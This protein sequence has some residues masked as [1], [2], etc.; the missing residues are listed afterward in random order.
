MDVFDRFQR[1]KKSQ[2]DNSMKNDCMRP[3]TGRLADIQ[4]T[5]PLW[6]RAEFPVTRLLLAP[7]GASVPRTRLY[8]VVE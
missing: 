8:E 2:N 4:P 1:S 6:E 7:S 5:F 3:G